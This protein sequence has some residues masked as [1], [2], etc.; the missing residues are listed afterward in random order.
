MAK[1]LKEFAL[2]KA[3][4]ATAYD[5]DTNEVIADTKNV[6][7]LTLNDSTPIDYLKGGENMT[8][9]IPFVGEQDASIEF[10]TATTSFDWLKLQIN[11]E[12]ST[13]K[14][15]FDTNEEFTLE[16]D[17]GK[18]E[19]TIEGLKGVS[20]IYICDKEAD[21]RDGETLKKVTLTP[22]H[23]VVGTTLTIV[24]D[25]TP[26]LD[27]DT[28]V[29][30][31]TVLA[32]T[33]DLNVSVGDT[34]DLIPA[35]ELQEKEFTIEGEKISFHKDLADETVHI[36]MQ[37]EIA[38]SKSV[39]SAGGQGKTVK[40]IVKAVLSDPATQRNFVGNIIC[41]KA[42]MEQNNNLSAKNDSV[43]DDIT[44]TFGCLYSKENKCSYEIVAVGR[45]QLAE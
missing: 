17:G 36:F 33:P 45:D 6:K 13:G 30:E 22:A 32:L 34:V 20:T 19:V 43:P 21:G 1:D 39:K 5:L 18:V 24:A 16:D 3:I 42:K 41:Y 28:Q 10:S 37:R 40:L 8:K 7:T 4:Q 9:L 35:Q 27:P 44:M 31:S 11:S 23:Y 14:K 2:V 12:A 26:S 25:G 29:E 15:V 38:E